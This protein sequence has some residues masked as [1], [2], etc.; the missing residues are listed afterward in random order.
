MH[1]QIGVTRVFCGKLR[2][3]YALPAMLGA[4]QRNVEL[5]NAGLNIR[6]QKL[7]N[8]ES[9]DL[10]Q[11]RSER[12]LWILSRR[13]PREE[14]DLNLLISCNILQIEKN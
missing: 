4:S 6:V 14:I 7:Q 3:K 12:N 9:G 10:L 8:A 11:R 1:D 5:L 13:L 2:A